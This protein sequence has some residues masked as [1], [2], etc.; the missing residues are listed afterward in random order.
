MFI[1]KNKTSGYPGNPTASRLP[2]TRVTT[3]AYIFYIEVND[4]WMD[5]N[6]ILKPHFKAGLKRLGGWIAKSF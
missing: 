1:S 3:S 2:A 6:F 4:K 5:G